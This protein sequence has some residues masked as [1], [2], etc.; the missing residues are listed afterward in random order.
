MNI[1]EKRA[2][3]IPHVVSHMPVCESCFQSPAPQLPSNGE[4]DPKKPSPAE[5][6][7]LEKDKKC[8]LH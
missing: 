1:L 5:E 4:C 2:K 6:K 8:L 3:N 7:I